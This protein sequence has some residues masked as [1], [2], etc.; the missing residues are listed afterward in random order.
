MPKNRRLRLYWVGHKEIG[1]IAVLAYNGR[2]AKR[3]I[4]RR[5]DLELDGLEW[6]DYHARWVRDARLNQLPKLEEGHI[7]S[8]EEGARSGACGPQDSGEL[9]DFCGAAGDCEGCAYK[10]NWLDEENNEDKPVNGGDAIATGLALV[11]HER[12]VDSDFDQGMDK[13]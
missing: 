12:E 7:L 11:N 5:G 2:D 6:I 1:G 8:F 13:S 9:C 3:F 4:S 10:D